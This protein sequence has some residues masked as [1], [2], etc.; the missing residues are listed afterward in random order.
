MGRHIHWLESNNSDGQKATLRQGT[1]EFRIT[2][3]NP[4]ALR[5]GF[6]AWS[7]ARNRAQKNRPIW[8]F[9][10]PSKGARCRFIGATE[11]KW[12]ATERLLAARDSKLP[13]REPEES[14]GA[15]TQCLG[16]RQLPAKLHALLAM[17]SALTCSPTRRSKNSRLWA[18]DFSWQGRSGRCM[19]HPSDIVEMSPAISVLTPASTHKFCAERL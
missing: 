3:Q 15:T 16:T 7:R 2:W 14:L 13:A 18:S 4:A 17:L 19:L 12:P 9:I 8:S 1:R 11:Q 6:P 10:A 5:P